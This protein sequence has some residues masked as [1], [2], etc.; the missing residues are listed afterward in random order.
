MIRKADQLVDVILFTDGACAP[1][2]VV[3]RELKAH[4]VKF[5]K[6]TSPT[7][8]AQA[9]VGLHVRGLP[10]LVLVA[11]GNGMVV[12]DLIDLAQENQAGGRGG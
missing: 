7:A 5:R 11:V 6:E 12:G 10:I 3:E 9:A 4:R 2:K 8:I 1:C